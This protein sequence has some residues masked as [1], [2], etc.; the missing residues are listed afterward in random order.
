MFDIFLNT[1]LQD[2]KRLQCV[3]DTF[4]ELSTK[5]PDSLVFILDIGTFQLHTSQSKT[6]LVSIDEGNYFTNWDIEPHETIELN[7]TSLFKDQ[8]EKDL[9]DT[10]KNSFPL[11]FV[12]PIQTPYRITKVIEYWESFFNVERLVGCQFVN[13]M[14]ED[15]YI[16]VSDIDE[17][18]VTDRAFFRAWWSLKPDVEQRLS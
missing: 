14:S 12:S 6:L 10:Y 9:F 5:M 4:P 15:L 16:I 8:E 17:I 11:G 1:N 13:D 7:E 3:D 18:L 2:I